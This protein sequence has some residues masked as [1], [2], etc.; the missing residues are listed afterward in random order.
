MECSENSQNENLVAI[1]RDRILDRGRIPFVEFM[2]LVLYHPRE[3]YYIGS[4]QRIGPQGDFYT[5]SNVHP[6]F[7]HLLARQF[8]QMWQILGEPASFAIAE[9]GAGRGLL[10]ADILKYCREHLPRFYEH[11]D[12]LLAEKSPSFENTQKILL[13]DFAAEGKIR[14]IQPHL[15]M[16]DPAPLTGVIFSNELIDS[17]PVHVVQQEGGK[18]QEIYVVCQNNIFAEIPGSPSTS[19]L[20]DYLQSYGVSLQEGQRAEINL[21]TLHW[22]EAVSRLLREGFVLTIDY[23]YEAE[24][25]YHPDRRRGTLRCYFRH[26]TSTNPFRR[27]GCQDI[28]AHVNFSA[29]VKKG[30]AVGLKKVGLTEQYK[31]LIA[32]GL[33]QDLENLEKNQRNFPLSEFLKNKL[34][35]KRFLLPGGMGSLFKVLVQAKGVGKPRLQGFHDPF[36]D[37]TDLS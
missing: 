17:L 11:V 1:I 36:V 7:G 25:L 28:T 8:H 33:L 34:A 29:L 32:L 14:W 30:E 21:E 9:M 37:G 4:R 24:I 12:Y 15:F 19:S 22:V 18:L 26:T 6:V 5:S 2:E 31:F 27:I 35:M 16:S 20:A 23:G 10:C 13:A 3:G